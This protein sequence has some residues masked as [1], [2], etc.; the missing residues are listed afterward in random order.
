M[1][2]VFYVLAGMVFLIVLAAAG[3]YWARYYDH[4]FDEKKIVS[5]DETNTIVRVDK[6]YRRLY[7]HAGGYAINYPAQFRLD[8]REPSLKSDFSDDQHNI[9]VY[10]DNFTGKI[11]DAKAYIGYSN[12]FLARDKDIQVEFNKYSVING[13]LANLTKWQRAKLARVENDKNHYF[14]IKLV[15]NSHQVYT[16]VI[17]SSQP[18]DDRE[19]MKLVKSFRPIEK[20][21]DLA[22]IV[23]QP[24][25]KNWNSETT[26]VYDQYF[27]HQ[28]DLKWG[29][30][31][32]TAPAKMK[33]LTWL[34]DRLDYDFHFL[35]RYQNLDKPLPVQ[36]LQSAWADQKLI[37]LT[38]QLGFEF[39][40]AAAPYNPKGIPLAQFNEKIIP[41]LLN[42]T[43][44]AYLAQYAQDIKDFG[45]PLLFRLNN[46]MNGDW[47]VYCSYHYGND[48][49]LYIEA[50]KYIYKIF[51]DHQV[52]NVIWVWNPHDLSFPDF[53]WN[54]Y[55]NYFPGS[56]YVDIIGLTGYNTGTYYEG[57]R[58]REFAAIYDPLYAEYEKRFA[59]PF[60]IT[61]FGSNSVGGDKARWL[62]DMF[63]HI[64]RYPS[65]KAAI[66]F[67]STDLDSNQ[68]PARIYRIDETEAVLDTVK[69][70]LARYQ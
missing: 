36:E 55:L 31:E 6:E 40:E 20:N 26:T 14:C 25:P 27:G 66:F 49:D 39:A 4:Y 12:G 37:E 60:M 2:K 32:P 11:S 18:I 43:F 44:D 16:I 70:G 56:E 50:W 62:Q 13:R 19:F 23:Y 33:N 46:E 24:Q 68:Q 34:E 21:N 52:D 29:I 3:F 53:A 67:S 58:W 48:A 64:D 38:L 5:A 63:A 7:N 41:E 45:H 54:H 28:A 51:A 9:E 22:G 69:Q 59:L 1:K 17:K 35:I 42:G 30:Y 61:E 10:S 57:E 15:E 8:V 47:C 65:I